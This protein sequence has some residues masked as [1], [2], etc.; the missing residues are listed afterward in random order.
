MGLRGRKSAAGRVTALAVGALLAASP[1]IAQEQPGELDPSA[2]L[3]P[4]PDLGVEWPDMD[5][6]DP[7]PEP[8]EGEAAPR[9]EPA[10]FDDDVAARRYGVALTGLGEASSPALLEAFNRRSALEAERDEA[11]N[12]AQ[13]ERR[14]RTDAELLTGLLQSQGYF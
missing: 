4:M 13:I 2:P 1:A 9:D 10:A 7:A 6:P 11:A 12:A 5:S 3:D 8:V 14:A